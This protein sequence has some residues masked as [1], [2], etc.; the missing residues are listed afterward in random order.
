MGSLQHFVLH[1]HIMFSKVHAAAVNPVDAGW[2]GIALL[3][4]TSF[5]SSFSVN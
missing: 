2:P 5:C 4:S 1:C 3:V